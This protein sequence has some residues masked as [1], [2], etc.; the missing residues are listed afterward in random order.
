MSSL[1]LYCS[2]NKNQESN[3]YCQQLANMYKAYDE[4]KKLSYNECF[5]KEMIFTYHMI[6]YGHTFNC[7]S[8]WKSIDSKINNLKFTNIQELEKFYDKNCL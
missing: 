5:N 3:E 4:N 7:R 2:I 8:E 1:R 6:N